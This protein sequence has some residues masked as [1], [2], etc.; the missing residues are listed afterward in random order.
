MKTFSVI[1]IGKNEEAHL[2][3]CLR[4]VLAAVEEVGEGEIV[5][6]DSASTDRSV[7]VARALGVRVLALRPEWKHTPAAGRYIGFQHTTGEL[8]MFV[9]GDC[10][11]D[12]QWLCRALAYFTEPDVA[13]IAGYLSDVDAEGRATPFVGEQSLE[14]KTLPT[15]RGIAAYRRAALQEAGSFNPHLRS[16]EEAEL[17]LR[18]RRAGWRLLH[19]PFPMGCHRRALPKLA[20][21]RRAWQLGRVSGLG[22]TWRYACQQGLG[23]RFCF[24][25]LRPTMLFL[26][27]SL[28]LSLGFALWGAGF[29]LIGKLAAAALALWW[30]AVTF[31]KRSLNGLVEY[32]VTHALILV[33]LLMGLFI[34]HLPAP[35]EYPLNVHEPRAE[36]SYQPF[37][38]QAVAHLP[39]ERVATYASQTPLPN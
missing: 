20:A 8:L 12:R 4:S 1:V 13:G 29:P 37:T 7:E 26:A 30:L 36:E 2:D 32:I 3:A 38:P 17:A 10:V 11:L 9:D 23:A 21:M 24:E 28:L 16:E 6:V 14:V 31:K 27:L 39:T 33:G 25:Q 18:L 34:Q 22:L 35:D 15:L 19:L 5:Y